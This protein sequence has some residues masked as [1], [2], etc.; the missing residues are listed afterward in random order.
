MDIRKILLCTDGEPHTA[1]AEEYALTLALCCGAGLTALYV[2]DPFLKKFT[3]EIYAVNRD[4]CRE[5]LESSLR[6]EG[7][8][9]LGRFTEKA[10]LRDVPVVTQIGHG[11]PEEV[12]AD[13]A[14]DGG[15]DIVILGSKVLKSWRERFESVNLPEKVF[16]RITV[17]VL[18][19]RP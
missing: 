14:A 13:M 11:A 8:E 6:R 2:I 9:A 4:E 5:H 12:I 18:F 1:R 7:E 16:R 3:N 17:P 10:S 19:V 15:Y